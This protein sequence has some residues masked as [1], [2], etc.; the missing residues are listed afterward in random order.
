MDPYLLPNGTLRNRLGLTDS[1]SL[2]R[3]E[4]HFVNLRMGSLLQGDDDGAPFDFRKL[5]AIHRHIFQD[6]YEWAGEPRTIGIAKQAFEGDNIAHRFTEPG[7]IPGRAAEIFAGLAARGELENLDTHAFCEAAAGVLAAINE[8]HPFRE[9]NGR[10]QRLFMKLLARRAGHDLDLQHISRE[11]N[12]E[13]S[14]AASKGDLAPLAWMLTEAVDPVL[15]RPVRNGIAFLEA[16]RFDWHSRTVLSTEPGRSYAGTLAGRNSD[17][18]EFMMHDGSRII[19]GWGVD[20]HC[21]ARRGDTI[22]FTATG[23]GARNA[24]RVIAFDCLADG[25][26]D[27]PWADGAVRRAVERLRADPKRRG[28][29]ARDLATDLASAQDHDPRLDSPR[30]ASSRKSDR[31]SLQGRGRAL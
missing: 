5:L 16:S 22:R 12:V 25:G 9:G 18:L 10:T 19:F 6:V 21:D 3:H 1:A 4:E 29:I 14:V 30:T 13:A 15:S 11:R 2:A 27:H 20:L 17:G 28:L 23:R 31:P 26:S 24:R 8:L 7:R